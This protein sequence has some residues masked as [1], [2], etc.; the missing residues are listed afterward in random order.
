MNRLQ[1]IQFEILNEFIKIC[2]NLDL[3]YYVI[4][5]S[6]LGC[7]K[8]EGFIPWDDDID[9]A[10]PRKDYDV[11]LEKAQD[12]LP[13]HYFLQNYRTDK[14][15][16]HFCSKIRDSRTTYIEKDQKTLNIHHGV[17]IDI[18]PLD[19]L[20]DDKNFKIKY[21]LFRVCQLIH[22][23]SPQKYK[24][25]IKFILKPFVNIRLANM[26]FEK[27]LRKNLATD[28]AQYC[29]F[30]NAKNNRLYME[31]AKYGE[32]ISAKFEGVDVIIPEKYDEYLTAYYGDW[33]ADLPVDQQVGH[34][35]YEILDLER[36]YTD[37]IEKTTQN[38]RKIKLRKTP[39]AN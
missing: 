34:H 17:F 37:Y 4:C 28:N 29:N 20:P 11:F 22:L 38:G 25:V 13:E 26:C 19:I 14:G 15:F 33:R 12:L 1:Q 32:G 31:F 21:R 27:Y 24:N 6:A 18:I 30:H 5:G 16:H 35:C 36:P 2:R 10:L 3:Q 9:V 7:V 23:R 8:Y 39:N